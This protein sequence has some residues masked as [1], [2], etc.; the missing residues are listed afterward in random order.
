MQLGACYNKIFSAHTL[1]E[2]SQGF[3]EALS[4]LEVIRAYDSTFYF[5][6][7]ASAPLLSPIDTPVE[8][9]VVRLHIDEGY[10]R[11]GREFNNALYP[12]MS[13]DS[14]SANVSSV[15]LRSEYF[16]TKFQAGL[17]FVRPGVEEFERTHYEIYG[18]PNGDAISIPMSSHSLISVTTYSHIPAGRI[19][20]LITICKIYQ[21][22][23]ETMSAEP[24]EDE[25][26]DLRP[27]ELECIRWLAA[28]KSLED[29]AELTNLPYRTVRYHLDTARGR[30]GYSSNMQLVVRVA[31]DYG[32]DP[33]Y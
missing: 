13:D 23:K 6:T 17:P 11:E 2:V 19:R 10:S 8:S 1:G 24:V 15:L 12:Q 27:V 20:D 7:D 32:L 16:R 22:K 14:N 29:I 31:L 30:Y 9:K 4:N 25:K 28:G 3:S 18:F 5:P 21:A 33:L 26:S